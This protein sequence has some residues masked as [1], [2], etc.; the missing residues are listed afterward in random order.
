MAS[1]FRFCLARR[2]ASQ[3]SQTD[4]GSSS[5]AAAFSNSACS[6]S[7]IRTATNLFRATSVAGFL[8]IFFHFVIRNA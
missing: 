6:P 4:S 1:Y 5:L 7:V 8:P 3:R 2:S